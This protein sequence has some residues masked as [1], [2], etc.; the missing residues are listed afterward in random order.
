LSTALRVRLST[1]LQVR[2]LTIDDGDD[3]IPHASLKSE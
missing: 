1:G 2:L 3:T